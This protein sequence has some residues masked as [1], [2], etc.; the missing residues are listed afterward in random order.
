M[1]VINARQ[2]GLR[3]SKQQHSYSQEKDR[4]RERGRERERVG[5]TF[6][7]SARFGQIKSKARASGSSEKLG[8]SFRQLPLLTRVPA[9]GGVGEQQHQQWATS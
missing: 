1:E 2:V 5:E 4:E 9:G 8:K 3:S 7:P 6:E